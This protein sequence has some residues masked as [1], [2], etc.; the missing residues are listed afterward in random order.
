MAL[1]KAFC[2]NCGQPTQIDDQKEF[3]FCLA[4]GNKIV[5]PRRNRS[6]AEIQNEAGNYEYKQNDSMRVDAAQPA[7]R[8]DTV[9]IGAPE[10]KMKEAEFYYK[11]SIQ[12]AEYADIKGEPTYYLKGQDLLVDLS[13]QYPSDYRIWWELSKPMDF[14]IVLDGKKSANPIVINSSYFNK[15]LDLAP[16]DQKMELVKQYDQYTAAKKLILEEIKAEQE[17]R[18]A[19]ERTRIEE[20]QR[21]QRAA[22]EES[23]RQEELRRQRERE[24]QERERKEAE[25]KRAEFARLQQTASR[26]LWHTLKNK[27]YGEID[28]SYFC[29]KSPEGASIIATFKTIANVL[30][31]SAF[32]I[33]A[34][35]GNT[36][37]LDQS[38][39]VLLNEEGLVTK[40]DNK[41]IIVRGWQAM[42]NTIRILANPYGGFFVNDI[43]L[44]KNA[45]YVA[46]ISKAAKKPIVSFNK[47]FS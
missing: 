6:T 13:Q 36:V 33:D 47:V 21:R 41:P 8:A 17:R 22:E 40:F 12:K 19:E 20:E 42:A 2:P 35:K 1:R 28:G 18:D 31:L 38:V 16:L 15:A 37:Y 14:N 29:F 27:Q 26:E 10:D 39:A 25:Q 30:Y 46:G 24:E 7:A 45:A 43:Q 9:N 44:V 11:L 23:I 3:C 5:V 34:N 32:R 4:C